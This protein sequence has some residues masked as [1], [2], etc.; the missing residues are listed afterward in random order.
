MKEFWKFS[1]KSLWIIT[2]VTLIVFVTGVV[3]G[4]MTIVSLATV[5]YMGWAMGFV[6]GSE[7]KSKLMRR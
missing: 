2:L 5:F 6:D 3:I 7:W 4:N 1:P